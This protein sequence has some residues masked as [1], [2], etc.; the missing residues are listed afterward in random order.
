MIGVTAVAFATVAQ[1]ALLSVSAGALMLRSG[2][3][4]Y[5]TTIVIS[6]PYAINPYPAVHTVKSTPPIGVEVWNKA[7]LEQSIASSSTNELG[8]AFKVFNADTMDSNGGK[9]RGIGLFG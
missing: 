3:S 7:P 9:T 1:C 4:R 2:A 6:P 5:S 8:T